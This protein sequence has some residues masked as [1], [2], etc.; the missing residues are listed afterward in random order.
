MS[1]ERLEKYWAA[2]MQAVIDKYRQFEIL[3]PSTYTKGAGHRAEDG[4]Y[5]ESLLKSTLKKFLPGGLE[6]FSG[7]ILKVGAK[8]W[9]AKS[10]KYVVEDKHSTQLDM[11]V[12]DKEC[13]PVYQV[14]A[15]TAVVPPEGV[16]AVISIKKRLY[17]SDLKPEF[18]ALKNV[19][20]LCA[21]SGKKGPFLGLVGM[22][23]QYMNPQ[24]AFTRVATC[25][26]EVQDK[27]CISYEELPG[28]VGALKSWTIHKPHRK[29]K[30]A[31]DYLLYIHDKE[32]EHLGIQYLLKGILDV[33]YS[34]GRGHGEE[35]R[36]FSFPSNR[37]FNGDKK[38][39]L[40]KK[41]KAGYFG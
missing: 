32:E 19:A 13:A 6:I 16:I 39:I 4:R 40:Y 38:T 26:E 8:S 28:F 3:I 17:A 2:E 35:P 31:A 1:G 25:I 37:Q 10:K 24:R 11:I 41:E 12:Y 34:K 20:E 30:K 14:F 33:Y 29:G 23:Y 36:M 22:E 5:V 15:D 9:D 27:K 18:T 21:Q 7:F